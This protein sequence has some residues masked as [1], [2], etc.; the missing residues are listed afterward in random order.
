VED[1]VNTIQSSRRWRFMTLATSVAVVCSLVVAVPEAVAAGPSIVTQTFSYTGSVASFTVPSGITALTITVTGGEGGNGGADATPAPA[2]GGYRGVVTGTIAVTQNQVLT[3]GVGGGGATGASRVSASAAAAIGGTNPV[4]GYAGGAGGKAGANGS[5]GAGGA[6]GAASVVTISGANVVAGGGGGSGG[7]G[8]YASTQG[9]TATA[10]YVGRTDTTATNG[11]T[12]V[13]ANDACTLTSCANNDGGGSGGG[14]GGAQGGAQGQI[15][16]GAGT[17]NEWYGFGGSVGQNS[18]GLLAGLTTSY[19]YYSDNGAPG[20]VVISYTTGPPAAPTAVNGTAANGGVDLVWTA[21]AD[22]GQS[23]ITDYLVR[24][25]SN[26]GSTWSSPVDLGTTATSGTVSSLINGTSYIFQVAA[27]NTVGTGVYS[28]SSSSVTPLGPPSAPGISAVTAQ[29]G[30]L[31]LSLT[32]PLSGAAVTGYDYR[33]NSGSWVLVASSSTSIVIPGLINGTSYTVDVRAESAVG[34]GTVSAPASGTP[35]AVPGAPTIS[36]LAVSNGALAVEFTPGFNGGGAIS[37]YEYQLNGGSWVA[38][39]GTSSPLQITG[40]AAGTTY[41]VALRAVNS[42]GTGAASAPAS[43]TTPALPGA[44]TISSVVDGDGTAHV[45]FAPGSTGG[46]PIQ[47]YEYQTTSAGP[48]TTVPGSSSPVL[49]TGLTNGTT[50]SVKIRAINAVGTGPASAATSVTPATV[51]GAPSIVGDTVAGSDATLSAA[52]TAPSSN[53]GSA[54]TTYEYSTDA[55]ATWRARTDGAGV[56]S[57]VVIATQSDDGTTPLTDGVTYFVE[58][59]AVNAKGAGTASAVASGISTSAPSKPT[60]TTVTRSSGALSVSFTAGANGGA[61]ITAYEYSVDHGSHWVSTGTLGTTFVISDLTN[62]TSYPVQVRAINASGTGAASASV[63]GTPAGLPGQPSITGVVRGDRTLTASVS[64]GDNGGSPV[65][66][67]QYSTD[68]GTSWFTASGTSSPLTL[69]VLS[70][71]GT[72]RLANGTGYALQVRAKTAIGTGPASSTTIVAPASAPTAPSIAVTPGNTSASVTFA[73][74]TDGGSPVTQLDYSLDG[75]ATWTAAGTLSSP[76]TISGL[77]NGTTYAVKLRADNAIGVGTPSVGASTTPRTVPGEPGL[78]TVASN[79]ASADVSWTAPS[80]TGGAPV[81]GYTASAYTTSTGT[82]AVSTCTTSGTACA[83]PGLTNGTVYYVEV[84]ATNAAG[85]GA[86]SSPRVLVTPLARPGAPTLSSLTV[87]DGSI[88]AA[89]TAGSAGD[90]AI[91]GYQYSIDGGATWVAAS[92]TSSPIVITGLTNGVTYTVAVRAVS[93]AGVGVSSNTRQGTPY[94]YPSAPDTSTIVANGGNGQITVSWAAANLNGGILLNYTATAFTGLTS[95]ST[96]A[97]CTTTTLTCVITGLTNGTTYYVSLQTQN[98]VSMYSV[99]ST[100]RVPATPSL[101]PGAASAVVA[102]AGN[103]TA[104][105]SWTAPMSTGASSITGYAVWCSANGGAYASC[106]T[107][108]GTSTVVTGLTN[109]S[110]YTFEVFATNSNGTGPASAAS[111]PV[112]PL[113]PGTVPVLAA[114]TSTVTGFTSTITNH[115]AATTYSATAINGA[116]VVV[117]GSGITV[118]GLAAGTSA[119]ATITATRAGYVTTQATVWGSALLAGITPALSSPVRTA[120]GYTFTITNFDVAGSYSLAATAG[121]ATLSGSTV[122]VTGLAPSGA[123][124]VT[125]TVSHSGYANAAAAQ[126]GN[127]LGAGTAP[128]FSAPTPLDGG[129]RFTITNYDPTQTY[130]F[131]QAD[132]A[133]VTRDGSTV[134]VS[135]LGVGV[136]SGTTVTVAGPGHVDVSATATGTSMPTGTAPVVSAVTRTVDGFFFTITLV[137]GTTYAVSSDAGTVVLN[138][139]TVTVTGLGAGTTTTVRVTASTSAALDATAHVTG[140]ALLTGVT[141]VF[142]VPT[143]TPDGYSFSVTN[144]DAGSIYGLDATAG[145]VTILGSTVTVSGLVPGAVS[146]VTVTVSKTGYVDAAATQSGN[147]LGA[148]TAPVISVPTRLAGG[149]RFTITNYDAAQTYSLVQADGATATREGDTVTVSGLAAGATSDTTVTAARAG[150]VNAS[151]S[152]SGASLADGTAPVASAVTRTG[153]GF[154]FTITLVPGTTYTVTSDSGTVVLSGSTVTVSGLAAGATTTVHVTASAADALDAST[155]VSGSALLAGITPLFDVPTRTPDGYSFLVTNFDANGTYGLVASAGVVTMSGAMVTVSGLAPDAVSMVT[156]TVSHTGFT[157]AAAAQSGNALGAGTVPKFSASTP[158]DGGYRF[159][160]TNYDATQTYVLTQADGATVSRDGDTVTVSGLGAGVTSATTVTAVSAGQVDVSAAQTGTSLPTGTAPVASDVTRTADG[161]TFTITLVPGTSYTV[162][163]GAGT[164]VLSGSTV[165]VTGLAAG[166]ITTVRV[167]ASAA[168]ALDATTDVSGSALLA[169]ITPVFDVPTR[170]PDG[171]SFTVTNLDADG[172]YTLAATAGTATMSGSTVAVTGLAPDAVSM[173]TV[174]V[175]HTGYTDAAAAQS[176]NAL[177]AG[178]VPVLAAATSTV[179]GYTSTIT[180]YDAATTYTATASNGATVVVTGSAITVSGLAA[181]ASA[182]I[183]V[184][185]AKAGYVGTQATG[186]GSALLA[187]IVPVLSAPTRTAGG[188][189]FAVTNFDAEAG[190]TL[191]A[192]AGTATMVGATV[193]V[194]GL[195]PDEASTVT[196]TVSLSGY[197]DV[198]AAQS[199]TALGAGTVPVFSAPT[200]LDGGYRFTITNYDPALTYSFDHADGV[201]VTRDGDTVTVSGL[202]A[203]VTSGTTVTVSSP[204]HVDASATR[205]G[206]SLHEG[207]APVTSAAASTAGGFVFTIVL[208]PGTS[209]MFTSDA[210]TV[211]VSGSTVTVTGLAPGQTATVHVTAS[212]P[213]A[214]DATTV[215]SGSALLAGIAP[216]LSS[217]VPAAGGFTFTITNYDPAFSYE[218]STTAGTVS[219]DGKTV[220][221]T[222]LAPSTSAVVQLVT[223]RDGYLPAAGSATGQASAPVPTPAPA[224]SP[225]VTPVTTPVTPTTTRSTPST[226]SDPGASALGVLQESK[227]GTGA[228]T[229]GGTSVSSTLTTSGSTVTVDA[230]N[231]LTLSV[232]AHR[233]GSPL[234]L[235]LD[236]VVEVG[237]GGQLWVTVTGFGPESGVSFWSLGNADRLAAALTG[238]TGAAS[239]SI[240]IPA[241][242]T[243]GVHTLVATGVDAQGKAVTMQVAI[244]V[245]GVT[246]ASVV[247]PAAYGWWIWWLVA[248]LVLLGGWWWFVIARR[249][250]REDEEQAA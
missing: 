136:T 163:S 4:S 25:S 134:T 39:S 160:I 158:L 209:Y 223:T 38:A 164:V 14:G 108:T 114:A 194:T 74:G 213:D 124:T 250:R 128:A 92:G 35:L 161:F 208:V 40:L 173:V 11:Q 85:T 240:V 104:S 95:G 123:S 185:A 60:I 90:R 10:T 203:G 218:L 66:A 235:G 37:S 7:S 162:S 27:V 112:T 182:E 12:G 192:S 63:T 229:N 9:H 212:T 72:T 70:A 225:A 29:D 130:T 83:I 156:V 207:S 174:T 154:R 191:V 215:V 193:T 75:G 18:T 219:R 176:G 107:S 116:T 50:Y 45:S 184:S 169:G 139:S 17:S 224:S 76:F 67:W 127:A 137:P 141:P 5:S 69:T 120:T 239:T 89:F 249:R 2:A 196:V 62:G 187:G 81:T 26:G 106:G 165:T 97:T 232:V 8:Q 98:N 79:T 46:S 198:A 110:I 216:T 132:G 88:S 159:T 59:R 172:S 51:P 131:V 155:D 222:G 33:V 195:L 118:S 202:A 103:T 122:T 210:G 145:T 86:A 199:G 109:G 144:F 140:S 16:F 178:T 245:T 214:L 30:A 28:S 248:L 3:V 150:Y 68:G 53:G 230:Q 190:Y 188:Y 23:A 201:T 138:G 19:V 243:E 181:G 84:A 93:S 54:I 147:A 171:F 41:S 205:T 64:L 186:S 228:V 24:Y 13:N 111:G 200:P 133:T 15:Q 135:G 82:T 22:T 91:T 231:G 247:S 78:V 226:A 241:G 44:P 175:S 189:S 206:T 237:P 148:G 242:L 143:R 1:F 52:F 47:G 236:G 96:A 157:D 80:S 77:N 21:P 87:G 221:V 94:T 99:R 220:T 180:N 152:V 42:V 55:G 43:A 71:D 149:Y 56:D 151:A 121:T 31:R 166:A 100:P 73:L 129:Y 168:D 167:T 177:G 142:D 197:A 125:V 113:A 204:G 227:P 234:P 179:D 126:S 211:V 49:I 246:P 65:T 34:V 153:D 101:Q 57:P 61:A 244:R 36:S 233:D 105:V 48:W 146:T 170:T 102:T 32:A 58:L 183:T 238:A 117:I 115:D 119:S 217:P 20:S 6:G